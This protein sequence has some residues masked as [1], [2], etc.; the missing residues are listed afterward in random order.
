[1]TTIVETLRAFQ[2][3]LGTCET[4]GEAVQWLRQQS[5]D[6]CGLVLDNDILRPMNAASFLIEIVE[7]HD[8]ICGHCHWMGDAHGT[9]RCPDCRHLLVVNRFAP[10]VRAGLKR[11]P[12]GRRG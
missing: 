4:Q 9:L 10:D 7:A 5:P 2:T 11:W 6:L 12:W 1:M 8:H 3:L